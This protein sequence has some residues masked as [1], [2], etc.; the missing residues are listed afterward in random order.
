[1]VVSGYIAHG[2]MAIYGYDT[3]LREHGSLFQRLGEPGLAVPTL[4]H[5]IPIYGDMIIEYTHIWQSI[6]KGLGEPGLAVPTLNHDIPPR[7]DPWKTF[8]A[9]RTLTLTLQAPSCSL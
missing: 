5:I 8:N 3:W 9:L 6:L 4:S 2:H 7:S 1:M